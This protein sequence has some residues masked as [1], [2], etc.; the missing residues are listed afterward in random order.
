MRRRRNKFAKSW[1]DGNGKEWVLASWD[2]FFLIRLVVGNN[3]ENFS[4]SPAAAAASCCFAEVFAV[5]RPLALLSSV[6]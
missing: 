4:D 3:Y 5:L 1:I 2:K 6:P